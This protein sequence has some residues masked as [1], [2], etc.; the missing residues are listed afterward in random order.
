MRW[1]PP[2]VKASRKGG[3]QMAAR[4]RRAVVTVAL[5]LLM[6]AALAGAAWA[7]TFVG[8]AGPD[9]LIG[10]RNTDTIY[11]LNGFDDI[12]GKP[13]DDELYGG[14]GEDSLHG[15]KGADYL[16]GGSKLDTFFGGNGN[17]FIDAADGGPDDVLCGTG[18]GDRAAVDEEDHAF[19]VF[20]CEIV[21]GE[22][23]AAQ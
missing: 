17:D 23:V 3:K 4:I 6:A 14:K 22:Q 1:C 15:G 20:G 18:K 16:V 5:A 2:L 11:G 19:G 12:S 10:T 7:A 21:N 13:G 8:T 9:E